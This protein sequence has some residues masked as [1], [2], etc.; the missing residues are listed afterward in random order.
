MLDVRQRTNARILA[1]A[2]STDIIM[3]AVVMHLSSQA[4]I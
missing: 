4:N 3:L 2:W 1:V